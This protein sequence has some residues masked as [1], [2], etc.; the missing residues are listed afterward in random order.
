MQKRATD[1]LTGLAALTILAFASKGIAQEPAKEPARAQ[2]SSVDSPA[3]LPLSAA[4]PSL[5]LGKALD[6]D[7]L[8]A[9]RGGAQLSDMKLDGVVAENNAVAIGATGT[10]VISQGAFAN[11][12]GVPMV[13]QNSGNNVLIQNATIVN[14]EVK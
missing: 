7:S 1:V 11:S 5:L 2:E 14:V 6:D 13:V 8:A 9:N 12:T 4:K 3:Q 10:N